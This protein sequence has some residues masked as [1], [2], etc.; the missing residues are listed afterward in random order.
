MNNQSIQ[1]IN[2]SN[3][4]LN[5]LAKTQ[6]DVKGVPTD[7]L[8]LGNANDFAAEGVNVPKALAG[9]PDVDPAIP[10]VAGSE[11]RGGPEAIRYYLSPMVAATAYEDLEQ[12]R[13]HTPMFEGRSQA[14]MLSYLVKTSK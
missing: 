11:G 14:D 5:I 10:E 3:A 6:L 9:H 12:K 7:V 13:N 8:V 4:T 2:F 1:V